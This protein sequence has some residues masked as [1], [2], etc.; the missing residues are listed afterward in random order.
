MTYQEQTAIMAAIALAIG[1]IQGEH[2][3]RSIPLGAQAVLTSLRTAQGITRRTTL[4][5]LAHEDGACINR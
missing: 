1:Y 5:D 4:I 3:D 2:N